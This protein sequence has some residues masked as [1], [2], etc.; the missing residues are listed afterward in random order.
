[1]SGTKDV[2]TGRAPEQAPAAAAVAAAPPQLPLQFF[3]QRFCV[4]V[5]VVCVCVCVVCVCVCRVCV[6][7]VCACVCVCVCRVVRPGGI[8]KLRMA[9]AACAVVCGSTQRLSGWFGR[10]S[11]VGGGHG[12]ADMQQRR[13]TRLDEDL[14]LPALVRQPALGLLAGVVGV[15]RISLRFHHPWRGGTTSACAVMLCACAVVLCVCVCRVCVCVCV[16]WVPS[17][18]GPGRST[19]Q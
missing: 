14:E 19:G 16:R 7:V 13:Q 5:C 15:H 8:S 18:R 2:G 9:C 12:Q 1:M 3:R 4:C 11:E 17:L 10:P 6:C